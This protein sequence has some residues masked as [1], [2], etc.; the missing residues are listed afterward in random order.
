VVAVSLLALAFALTGAVSAPAPQP[1]RDAFD[2][3]SGAVPSTIAT[4]LGTN[5]WGGTYR[6][7]DGIR[8][9]VYVSDEY[10]VDE[11]R[12]RA[13]V[14]FLG[15]IPHG[16]ELA[17]LTLYVAPESTVTQMCGEGALGCYYHDDE[18]IF[19]VGDEAELPDPLT[20]EQVL[21]HEYGHHVANNRENPPWL[22]VDKGT[23]RW[24]S[25]ADVCACIRDESI[26]DR[27]D[28]DPGEPFAETYRVLVDRLRGLPHIWPIV[29]KLFAP[30]ASRLDAA[31]TDVLIPWKATTRRRTGRLP[32]VGRS[33]SW[34]VPAP[35]DGTLTLSVT[36][37]GVRAHLAVVDPA[38]GRTLARGTGHAR[39]VV[40]GQRKVRVDIRTIAGRGA[41]TLTTVQA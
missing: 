3:S 24:A 2:P 32:G 4:T 30:T 16:Q 19:V 25:V 28:R 26:G 27:Y 39:L 23:K 11:A 7:K 9:R 37:R 6:G 34:V 14:D 41:F 15:S 21:A 20:V 13:W 17:D 36:G 35:W 8:I 22:A 5:W 38:S 18:S 33:R 31:R 12:A 40:C 10:P 29:D 1:V